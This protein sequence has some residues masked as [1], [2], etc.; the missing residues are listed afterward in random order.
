MGK[1][2]KDE[3]KWWYQVIDYGTPDNPNLQ[4]HEVYFNTVN[5]NIVS[6]TVNPVILQGYE[7][8]EEIIKD[9]ELMLE[10]LKR[11]DNEVLDAE[12]VNQFFEKNK[13]NES[14]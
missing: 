9:L 12:K 13:A 4:V 14:Y 8:K 10:D 2:A 11:V 1:I 3:V 5:K 7:S 6:H